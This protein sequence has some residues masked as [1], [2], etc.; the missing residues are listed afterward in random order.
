MGKLYRILG[1]EKSADAAT[2]KKA[3]KK[4]VRQYHPDRN[5]SPDA[6]AKFQEIKHAYEV[7]SNPDDRVIYDQYGDSMFRDGFQSS[8]SGTSWNDSGV[9]SFDSFF[10]G[11]T[12]EEAS[13]YQEQQYTWE[14]RQ[15]HQQSY[16]SQDFGFGSRRKSSSDFEPP[17]RGTDIRVDLKIGVLEAIQGCEKKIRLRRPSRWRNKD[18]ELHNEVVSVQ[19]PPNT[20]SG[21]EIKVPGKGNY[22]KGGGADGHLLVS[23]M[24]QPSNQ[25]FREGADLLLIVPITLK[26]A[27][28]GGQVEVPTM[29]KKVKVR[30]PKGVKMGQKLRIKGRGGPKNSGNG[31]LYLILFPVAPVKEGEELATLA[32]ELEKF[33]PSEGVRHNLRFE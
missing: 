5:K 10:R 25:L 21:C 16:S 13:S 9:G 28:E 24:V 7:L 32:H 1:I 15:K 27:L 30:L 19:V 29:G 18:S 3:Y 8:T 12:G 26:E 20:T 31:D 2:I 6:V 4:M 23:V 33:Y 17:E 14:R 11:F 22:G